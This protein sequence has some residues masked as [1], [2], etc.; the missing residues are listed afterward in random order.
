MT[1]NPSADRRI[2]VTTLVFAA[3]LLVLLPTSGAFASSAANRQTTE[4]VT[5]HSWLKGSRIALSF[6]STLSS[7]TSTTTTPNTGSS[8]GSSSVAAPVAPSSYSIPAGAVVVSS[9]S[10]LVSAL[11]AGTPAIVLADGTYGR[12]AG[13]NDSGSSSLYA[14]HLGGAVLTAGLTVGGNWGSGGAVVQGL[15]FNVSDPSA[16]FQNSELNVWGASGE[17]THVLDCIFNGN[18]AVGIG[19]DAV[20][21]DGL[22]AQRLQFTA[23]ADEGIRA[24]DNAYASYGGPTAVINSITD[25]SINGVA[26]SSPGSSGGTAEA[27]LWIG[28]PVTNGVHRIA[29][30]D[31][32]ISGIE[33]VNNSWNTSFSDLNIDMSGPHA[34]WGIGVYMEHYTT[35]DTFTNFTITGVQTG[36]NAEWDDGIAGN[37]AAY[38]DTIENGTI[39]ASGETWPGNTVGVYLDAGTGPI[40]ITNVTFKNQNWAA[41]GAYQNVAPTT[42][43]GNTYQLAAG[44]VQR[45]PNHV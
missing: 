38:N 40:T 42:I 1:K 2:T 10:Q 28:E 36:F 34:G 31:V 9:S 25:I 32:A 21:P 17:N 12:S 26:E 16:T 6:T 35:H 19:L 45:S 37:A 41:I 15:A 4:I 8:I 23:F 18:W 13:F 14:Q 5:K 43:T 7:S 22:V 44:A 11:A 3:L 24:S 29:I 39:D 27:G 30:K 33:T 20:N